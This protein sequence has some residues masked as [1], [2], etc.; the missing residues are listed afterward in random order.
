MSSNNCNNC[1]WQKTIPDYQEPCYICKDYEYW[2]KV[3]DK[4][5]PPPHDHY[6]NEDI[7]SKD[8]MTHLEFIKESEMLI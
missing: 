4:Y 5:S 8:N 3:M 6:L 2:K 7:Y 1:H